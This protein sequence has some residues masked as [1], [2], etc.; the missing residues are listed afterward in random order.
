[1]QAGPLR[2]RVTIV[3]KTEIKTPQF[4][5]REEPVVIATRA[6]ASVEPLSGR[7]LEQAQQIAPRTTH[8]V[9]IRYRTGIKAGQQ[10]TYHDGRQGDRAFEIVAPPLDPDEAHRKLE[11]LCRE[12]VA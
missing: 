10:V 12:A 5:F 3:S 11:L 9:T 2:Q 4:G 1:M 6:P 7:E 8:R